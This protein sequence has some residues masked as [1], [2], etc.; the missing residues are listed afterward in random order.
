M[1]WFKRTRTVTKRMTNYEGIKRQQ[2]YLMRL[3]NLLFRVKKSEDACE[4]EDL[5]SMGITDEKIR[6]SVAAFTRFYRF[7]FVIG[8]AILIYAMYLIL[9]NSFYAAIV[10]LPLS[11]VCF[12]NAFKYHFWVFQVKKKKLGCS[13]GEWFH[14]VTSRKG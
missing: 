10:A 11:L 12:A 6:K 3:F 7:F 5:S 2:S 9:V 1:A 14:Y 8:L 13:V 4:Y